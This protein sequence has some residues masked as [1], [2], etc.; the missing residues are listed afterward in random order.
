MATCV[1]L[2]QIV[3]DP[4]LIAALPRDDVPELLGELE[5]VRTRL[6]AHLL[7]YRDEQQQTERLSSDD[8]LLT[9]TEAAQLLGVTAKWLYRHHRYLPFARR[10]SRKVMRFS[11][12][13]AARWL[14]QQ[15]H[16]RR[17]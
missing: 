6:W 9:A 4:G 5:R 17:A 12:L 2:A 16:G 14:A 11:S 10:L 3:A 7:R 8:R 13:G 1:R 15:A